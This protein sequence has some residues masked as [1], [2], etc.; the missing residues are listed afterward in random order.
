[1]KCLEF[2]DEQLL[3]QLALD[4]NEKGSRVF[5]IGKP[6]SILYFVYQDKNQL[7]GTE[8]TNTNY[9]QFDHT[10]MSGQEVMQCVSP[11]FAS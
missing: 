1:L 6:K 8:F 3:S 11:D 2:G 4:Y 10:H 9:F 7:K 5:N